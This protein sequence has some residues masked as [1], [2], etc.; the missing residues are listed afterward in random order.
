MCSQ[1][2]LHEVSEHALAVE[3]S[4]YWWQSFRFQQDKGL[5]KGI[6]VLTL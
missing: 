4:V 5:I 1:I 6:I 2:I 3:L